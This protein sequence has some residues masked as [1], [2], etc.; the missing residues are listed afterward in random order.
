MLALDF[1]AELVTTFLG[2]LH[3]GAIPC[4]FPSLLPRLDPNAYLDRLNQTASRLSPKAIVFDS[5]GHE[6]L[7]S[8]SDLPVLDLA[9]IPKGNA[10]ADPAAR[11]G[12]IRM[13]Y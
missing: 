5:R 4:I 6:P 9:H 13:C 1:C 12:H 8:G 2:A 3:V 7:L 10:S 11:R